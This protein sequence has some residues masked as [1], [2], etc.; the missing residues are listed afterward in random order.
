MATTPTITW[1]GTPRETLEEATEAI[2]QHWQEVWA[3]Q[4]ASGA[5]QRRREAIDLMAAEYERDPLRWSGATPRSRRCGESWGRQR[6][7]PAS[8]A[9]LGQSRYLPA[10][11]A[12]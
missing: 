6:A 12:D 7:A 1:R 11:V 10:A 2:R 9:G 5:E 4:A 3:P 8:T